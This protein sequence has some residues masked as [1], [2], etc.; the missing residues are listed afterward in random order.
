MVQNTNDINTCTGISAACC[1][2]SERK[3]MSYIDESF[4]LV[5]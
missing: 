3:L 5:N 2:V 4:E 1:G